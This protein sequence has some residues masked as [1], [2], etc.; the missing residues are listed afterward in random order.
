MLVSC[1]TIASKELTNSA[2]N[3]R[4]TIATPIARC[5][6]HCYN[7][8]IPLFVSHLEDSGMTKIKQRK[9]K[10]LQCLARATTEE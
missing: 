10:C 3:F 7:S 5:V 8:D 1:L 4:Y 6:E 2:K 9:Y